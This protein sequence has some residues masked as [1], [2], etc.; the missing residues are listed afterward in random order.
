[1]SQKHSSPHRCCVSTCGVSCLQDALSRNTGVSGNRKYWWDGTILYSGWWQVSK[2]RVKDFAFVLFMSF[3]LAQMWQ[4]V[5]GRVRGATFKTPD[6]AAW[7]SL[8]LELARVWSDW[9]FFGLFLFNS[10]MLYFDYTMLFLFKW[11]CIE[12]LSC[13]PRATPAKKLCCGKG[14]TPLIEK[15]LSHSGALSWGSDLLARFKQH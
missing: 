6:S 9:H 13:Q 7:R 10:H 15:K 2:G 5:L 14:A 1:M 8:R 11:K 3:H 4:K 12:H